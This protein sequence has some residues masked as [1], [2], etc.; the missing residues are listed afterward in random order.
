MAE[1]TYQLERFDGP[2]DL[3]LN[4]IHKNKVN[5]ADIPIALICDQYLA[6][7]RAAERMNMELTSDFI[8]M[9]SELMLIKSK[10]L[11]P[12]KEPDKEDPRQELAQLLVLYQQAK[13]GARLMTPMYAFFSGRMV[14]DTD[15]ISPDRTFVAD[16]EVSSLVTALRRAVSE[17]NT[18]PKED[19]ATFTPMIAKP[20]VSVEVK[21]VG[22][23]HHIEH[24]GSA[25][26]ASLLDDSGAIPDRI[27]IFLGILELMKMR[28]ILLCED[29]DAPRSVWGTDA[30]FRIN[31]D[32]P[33]EDTAEDITAEEQSREDAADGEK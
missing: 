26:L 28:R 18:R 11:L 15:E 7:L 29:P 12:R 10:M 20:I 17:Y 32:P 24:N 21:I 5:I 19:P 27:A 3:L 25:T 23:L 9:A 31:D 2:L 13:D 22:I 16:Q 6:Y 14:K 1:I 30:V 4:L 33:A 8:V